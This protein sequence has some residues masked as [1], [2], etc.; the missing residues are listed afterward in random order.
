MSARL[1]SGGHKA[2]QGAKGPAFDRARAAVAR[3]GRGEL[4]GGRG[5]GG[6]HRHASNDSQRRATR[7]RE[8]SRD[9]RVRDSR[10]GGPR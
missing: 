3:D 5:R 2:C 8:L 1:L 6:L 4:R 10:A 9:A 7:P